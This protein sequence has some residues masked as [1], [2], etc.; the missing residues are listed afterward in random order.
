MGGKSKHFLKEEAIPITFSFA[1]EPPI[2]NL[3]SVILKK[4]AKKLCIKKA[5]PSHEACS[6]Y[7]YE[8]DIQELE[9]TSGKCIGMEPVITVDKA[10]GKNTTTKSVRTQYN[11]LYVLNTLETTKTCKNDLKVKWTT[12]KRREKV[13]NMDFAFQ[14][15]TKVQFVSPEDSV[16]AS[17]EFSDTESDTTIDNESDQPYNPEETSD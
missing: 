7:V 17:D 4:H 16:F 12:S 14:T 10:A 2:E 15:T 8:E 9:L 3:Q 6:S 11:P 13:V 5:I 1:P